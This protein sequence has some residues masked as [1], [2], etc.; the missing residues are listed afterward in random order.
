MVMR[1]ARMA[2]ATFRGSSARKGIPNMLIPREI[3]T[4]APWSPYSILM[5]VSVKMPRSKL[6]LASQSMASGFPLPALQLCINVNTKLITVRTPRAK[7]GTREDGLPSPCEKNVYAVTT[8]TARCATVPMAGPKVDPRVVSL[9]LGFSSCSRFMW[10]RHALQSLWEFADSIS[11][12]RLSMSRC[13]AASLR[14][15]NG[16]EA[17]HTAAASMGSVI[18]THSPAKAS[19]MM[20]TVAHSST[21]STGILL[22]WRR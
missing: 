13:S 11:L 7:S 22:P 21:L 18:K 3:R 6:T 20:L 16:P 15:E 19:T 14:Q 9:R 17:Q 4:W 12:A 1:I 10:I 8:S 5:Y 2:D